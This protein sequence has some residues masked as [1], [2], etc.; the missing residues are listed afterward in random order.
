M[1]YFHWS[2]CV[3]GRT[4]AIAAQFPSRSSA[5]DHTTRSP[6]ATFDM[7]NGLHVGR[8]QHHS[9]NVRA[10]DEAIGDRLGREAASRPEKCRTRRIYV[11]PNARNGAPPDAATRRAVRPRPAM[12]RTSRRVPRNFRVDRPRRGGV[13]LMTPSKP[14]QVAATPPRCQRMPAVSPP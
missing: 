10:R 5:V 6:D 9:P 1:T 8:V 7:C 4:I 12:P 11:N 14:A 13:G 3:I 2:T